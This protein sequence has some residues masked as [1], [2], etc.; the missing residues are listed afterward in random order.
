MPG[1]CLRDKKNDKKDDSDNIVVALEQCQ[2]TWKQGWKNLTQSRTQY[3]L[4]YGEKARKRPGKLRTF[5]HT[6]TWV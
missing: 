2:R 3:Y 6:S 1:P 5:A 4:V